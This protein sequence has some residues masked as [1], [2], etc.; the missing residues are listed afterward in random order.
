MS[1][2]FQNWLIEQRMREDEG[3]ED[4]ADV[5][6]A[7]SEPNALTGG[8]DGGYEDAVAEGDPNDPAYKL[9]IGDENTELTDH[10]YQPTQ[11]EV[12]YTATDM[13]EPNNAVLNAV[14]DTFRGVPG[15]FGP[16]SYMDDRYQDEMRRNQSRALLGGPQDATGNIAA[17][18]EGQTFPEELNSRPAPQ[19]GLDLSLQGLM[20]SGLAPGGTD[21][22]DPFE[23]AL[24]AKTTISPY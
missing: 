10:F 1:D 16:G 17:M 2:A 15:T 14:A 13:T 19:P 12:P 8:I 5:F 7:D 20:Q 22:E 11:D 21:D 4:P 18:F 6:A 24:R 23:R 9:M 3:L